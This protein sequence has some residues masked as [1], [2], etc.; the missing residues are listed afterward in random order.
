MHGG[1]GYA[2]MALEMPFRIRTALQIKHV[3]KDDGVIQFDSVRRIQMQH[4]ELKAQNFR[5]QRVRKAREK[6]RLVLLKMHPSEN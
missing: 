3:L 4:A 6:A 2:R 1:D 5:P